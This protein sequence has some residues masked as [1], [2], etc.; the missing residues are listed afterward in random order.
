MVMIDTINTE[1]ARKR[2][3]ETEMGKETILKRGEMQGRLGKSSS[4]WQVSK[5]VETEVRWDWKQ[6]SK[7]RAW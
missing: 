2:N 6:T 3:K 4:H 1:D 7:S 5:A